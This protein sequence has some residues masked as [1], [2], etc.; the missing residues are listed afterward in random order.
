MSSNFANL[1][2]A[3]YRTSAKLNKSGFELIS[4]NAHKKVQV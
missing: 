1:K 4:Q 2:S 3:E